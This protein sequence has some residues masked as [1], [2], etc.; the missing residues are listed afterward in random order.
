MTFDKQSNNR[1][2][3]VESKS[4][5]SFNHRITELFDL[6]TSLLCRPSYYHVI[7]LRTRYLIAMLNAKSTEILITVVVLF[8]VTSYVDV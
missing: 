5:R 3:A 2:T 7:N 4:N 6:L 1:R 8:T